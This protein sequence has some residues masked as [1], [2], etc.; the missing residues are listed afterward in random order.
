MKSPFS[1]R[2]SYDLPKNN[3]ASI[4]VPSH[5]IH[6][7]V[8][9]LQGFGASSLSLPTGIVTAA[10]L[11]RILGP[12]N[13]GALT[14]AA[15]IVGWVELAI[16]MGFNRATVKFVAETDNWRSVST[17]FLQVQL[18]VSLL[19]A[20]I[21]IIAAPILASWLHSV[22][23]SYYLRLFSM[24][25]PFFA[26]FSIHQSILVGRG[27]F[28]SRACLIAAYWL[29]RMVLIILFVWIWPSVASAIMALITVYVLMLMSS[30]FFINPALVGN[31]TLSFNSLWDF[32][33]PL[34]CY[35]VGIS[36]FNRLDLF[37]VK[38]LSGIPEA[39]GFYGAAQN[40]T[41]VPALFMAS[42]SPLLL[43]KLTQL[44]AQDKKAF[45][46]EM[47]QKA[48]RLT[49][50][51]LPFAGMAAGAAT[52]VAVMIYG[53][54][55]S[56]TGRILAILILGSIGASLI[57]I[58]STAL[59]S[60]DRPELTFYLIIP[61]VALAIGGH[62]AFI[63][64]FGAIGAAVVTTVLSWFGACCYLFAVHRVWQVRLPV[65]TILR[66]ITVCVLAYVFA[67]SWH[68]SGLVLFLKIP[69]ISMFIIFAVILLREFSSDEMAFVRQLFDWRPGTNQ[70]SVK[71]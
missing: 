52:E 45:A 33:L 7:T 67:S 50:S 2:K 36:L 43:S 69:A 14:V 39:A 10:F 68:T 54:S 23:L 40:L 22:E 57:V 31:S 63:P 47:I 62:F 16:T 34:F 35:A 65:S 37:F 9:T 42:L 25:I 60:V 8:G 64:R 55:F 59:V 29:S 24:G 53:Q 61:I 13:Y 6:I 1:T 71:K 26:L 4:Q 56:P 5:G 70:Y 11:S 51:L 66:S 41:I 27:Y 20:F 28:G 46:K 32:A 17:R 21:L 15:S 30:R 38:G 12:A 19:A 48:L 44:C 49:F 3:I 58:S 18:M